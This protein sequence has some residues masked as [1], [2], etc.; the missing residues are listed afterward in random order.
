[1]TYDWP[2]GWWFHYLGYKSTNRLYTPESLLECPTKTLDAV[3]LQLNV[4]WGNYG[5]NWSLCKSNNEPFQ[6]HDFSGVPLGISRIKNPTE[7]LLVGDSGYALVCWYHA[8]KQAPQKFKERPGFETSYI[9]G[10]SVNRDR[11]LLPAQQADA[12]GGRHP[13]KT[14]NVG[15]VDGHVE[16]IKAEKTLVEQDGD[17]YRNVT[18]FWDPSK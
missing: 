4:L 6:F 3:S 18:P 9:P 16:R 11:F 13:N 7:V 1:M 8:T 17:S 14:I 12:I 10:L 5:V 15:Y 2:G